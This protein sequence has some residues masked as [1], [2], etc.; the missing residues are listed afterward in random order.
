MHPELN[1]QMAKL[2]HDELTA[3]RRHHALDN[4]SRGRGLRG[5]FRRRRDSLTAAATQHT[6]LV[7]LPPPRV[8][9]DP[10]G[11]DDQRVA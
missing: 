9:H 10:N 5:F 2:R 7:L 4:V 1:M 3:E 11:H 6:P 8:E